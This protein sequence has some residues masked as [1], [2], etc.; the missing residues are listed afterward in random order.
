MKKAKTDKNFLHMPEYP[1]GLTA[2]KEF[3]MQHLKYPEEAS[4]N[5][6]YGHVSVKLTINHKGEV[7]LTEVLQ[8]LGY[9]CDAE[10]K[11]VASLLKFHVDK[12]RGVKIRFFK[13]IHFNFHPP[14][15]AALPVQTT[16][17]AQAN[18]ATSPM[19]LNY[20]ITPVK[21]VEKKHEKP[22]VATFSYTITR[23]S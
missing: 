11:R 21:P 7:I 12:N 17:P 16:A 8:G 20:T 4:K 10:A 23:S 13:T 9:G 15:Q 3:I 1:G 2:M 22:A 6:I 18:N 5:N 14:S 19:E